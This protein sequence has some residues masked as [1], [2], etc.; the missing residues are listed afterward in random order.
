[1]ATVHTPPP[2]IFDEHKL[3]V[4][5]GTHHTSDVD[6]T[7]YLNNEVDDEEWRP[8]IDRAK[9]N[10][11]LIAAAPDLLEA[12]EDACYEIRAAHGEECVD[13]SLADK[14]QDIIKKAKGE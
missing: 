14:L 5:R 10:G 12:C 4:H 11:R 6:D 13:S 7:C 2:W 3:E 9:A 1:M 8:D